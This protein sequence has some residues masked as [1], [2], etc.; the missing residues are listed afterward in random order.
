MRKTCKSR[1]VLESLESINLLSSMA[2]HTV[3]HVFV[4]KVA[5]TPPRRISSQF[6]QRTTAPLEFGKIWR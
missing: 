6:F 2:G 1:P 5:N 4:H 3:A